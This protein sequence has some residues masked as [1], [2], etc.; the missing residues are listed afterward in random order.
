MVNPIGSGG[1][2]PAYGSQGGEETPQQEDWSTL[3]RFINSSGPFEYDGKSYDLQDSINAVTADCS[4]GKLQLGNL[5]NLYNSVSLLTNLYKDSC[6][7]SG[8]PQSCTTLIT[9]LESY[10]KTL[11][12]TIGVVSAGHSGS[13]LIPTIKSAVQGIDGDQFT[14]LHTPPP[15]AKYYPPPPR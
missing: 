11:K 8:T 7:L 1:Q 13:E 5:Q 14:I 12:A 9:N 2:I 3:S 10:E 4:K 15:G 6:P